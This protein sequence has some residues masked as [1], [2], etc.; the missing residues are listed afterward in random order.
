MKG[1][2]KSINVRCISKQ[3]GF[4]LM[5]IAIVM[6]IM[7]ALV[8]T[9]ASSLWNRQDTMTIQQAVV[10]ITKSVP[11]AMVNSR[12]NGYQGCY[13]LVTA[14]YS[15]SDFAGTCTGL[16]APATMTAA[17]LLTHALIDGGA[18]EHTE[19]GGTWYAEY[20]TGIMRVKYSLAGLDDAAKNNLAR[21]IQAASDGNG[22]LIKHDST[23]TVPSTTGVNQGAIDATSNEVIA[24]LKTR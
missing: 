1:N 10:F 21:A 3:K 11:Q 20:T 22:P 18:Q 12:I 17:N 6:L 2:I 8:G 15:D 7:A 16:T 19:W 9:M 14:G 13:K 23:A 5:E 24:Y 4:T